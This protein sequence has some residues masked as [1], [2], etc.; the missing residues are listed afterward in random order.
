MSCTNPL[1]A[2][3]LYNP[4]IGKQAIKI[5][6]RSGPKLDILLER[7]KNS[8][9]IQLPCGHCPSCLSKRARE[10][11]VRCAIEAQD[12]KDNCFVTLTYDPEHYDDRDVKNDWKKFIKALRNR[13]ISV[14]YFGSCEKGDEFGRQHFH[15]LLFGYFPDDVKIWAKSQK[16]FL[17]YTSKTIDECWNRGIATVMMFSP[18]CASYTAGYVV[19]K[20][21]LGEK[22]SFHFQST[23]PG[24]GAAYHFHKSRSYYEEHKQHRFQAL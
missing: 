20:F 14:R 13:G 3:R 6:P 22:D 8:E 16:G 24:I 2:V 17:Q 19:K 18:Y 4:H 23:K 9:I 21:A 7:Y 5:L 11:S 1:L 15:I 12:H 10:W